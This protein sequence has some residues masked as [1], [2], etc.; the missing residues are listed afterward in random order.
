MTVYYSMKQMLR[1]PLKSVLFF[2]LV[3][4]SA[5][6][7]ALG[8]SL[9]KMNA[10]MVRE[11]ED[12]F[13][14]IGTVDQKD[15]VVET[16]ARWDAGKGDYV[17]YRYGRPGKYIPDSVL[18]FEGAGYILKA[19]QRP[20]FGARIEEK[21]RGSGENDILVAE[22]TAEVSDALEHSVPMRVNKV[23]S[24]D[25]DV[26]DTVYIC[27]HYGD[28]D[29]NY[30]PRRVEEGKT[31]IMGLH[32]MSR[33]HGPWAER[34]APEEHVY[35]Y[36]PRNSV[37]SYQYTMDGDRVE[38]AVAQAEDWNTFDEVTETFYETERGMRWLEAA[39]DQDYEFYTIP[40]EPVDATTLLM[41]FYQNEAQIIKGRDITEEEY[42][43]GKNV[44]L[45]PE[46]LSWLLRKGEGDSLTLP[47]YYAAY[48]PA[49]RHDHAFL[50][51]ILNARGKVYPVFHE[52][53]YE[54]VGVYKNTSVMGSGEH[55]LAAHEVIVPW[56]SIPENSWADNIV[57]FEP[58]SEG[59][60][61]FQIPNGTIDDFMEAWE[62]QGV[63]GLEIKFY[64]KGYSQL[65]AGI[66]NRKLMAWIFLVSGCILAVMILCFFSNL[67]ITGQQE[68]IAVERLLG[69]TKKQCALS[70]LTGLFVLAA[71]GT[72]AGSA[73][74]W[75][76][77]GSAVQAT[78][79]TTKF[80]TTFSNTIIDSGEEEEEQVTAKGRQTGAQTAVLAGCGMM[81]MAALISAAFLRQTLEK[82]PLQILGEL[83]E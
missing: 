53:D 72:A 46:P 2:L 57:G 45:I 64:D 8:G 78:E 77:T 32:A 14:T 26:G 28:A 75:M 61:S 18:D 67:F 81:L 38:D 24:G 68:R 9:S 48:A 6:L 52:E 27:D 11:F 47:L 66:E 30:E 41:P 33:V 7:L 42:R 40:V 1:S 82:E 37:A 58:M 59:N 62:Q 50:S 70:I 74:G 56:N 13:T 29:G 22:L 76:A 31:Y 79:Q 83:E 25:L 16:Y 71:A 44:C 4:A 69:R 54:I 3:G 39:K 51:S 63:D 60:T 15:E 12:I 65:Q 21:V 19:R 20:Y 10:E 80:D 5:F 43:E 23:L 49:E 34:L 55:D 35:E 17:Y 36:E 73:A